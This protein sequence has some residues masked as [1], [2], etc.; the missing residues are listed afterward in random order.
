MPEKK[1]ILV[2]EPEH[3]ELAPSTVVKQQDENPV[4]RDDLTC[5]LPKPPGTV[6]RT[7][8]SGEPSNGDPQSFDDSF[9]MTDPTGVRYDFRDGL[10]VMI[11]A[12]MEG[13]YEVIAEDAV[14][15]FIHFR[16]TL[17]PGA[18]VS[19]DV[20]WFVPW[21]FTV[22]KDGETVMEHT[23]DMTGK[24]VAIHYPPAGLGDT[25]AWFSYAER[26][27]EKTGCNLTCCMSSKVRILF[28]G[29]Y[30][31]FRWADPDAW[32]TTPFYAVYHMGIYN[33]DNECHRQPD[34]F[35]LGGLHHAA[36]HILGLP[37]EDMPPRVSSIPPTRDIPDKPYVCIATT[38]SARC[39]EWLNPYGWVSLV[40]WLTDKGY[41]VVDI[42]KD[43]VHGGS[44]I[45]HGTVDDTGDIDLRERV[46]VLKGAKAFVGVSSGLAWLA[47]ACGVKTVLVSG[48]T[49]PCTEFSTPWRVI[50]RAV[51]HGCWND[52]RESFDH[53]DTDYCPRHRDT[54]RQ[55]E[56]SKAISGMQVKLALVDALGVE[57]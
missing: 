27:A 32:R 15:G 43:F 42:D 56:C 10:R 19:S 28:E 39:K 44:G 57:P 12:S 25:I 14:T 4:R 46:S 35:R 13:S 52:A 49:L 8:V 45:P 38:A 3:S 6:R 36:G 21:R 17:S 2:F 24:E 41:A 7:T 33:P 20:K 51:C 34:D 53:Y 30:P 11:P 55:H 54:P 47:W 29:E 1:T 18:S 48:W 50:N 22:K 5:A 31:S 26:F 16:E 23:M 37:E 40:A 9:S